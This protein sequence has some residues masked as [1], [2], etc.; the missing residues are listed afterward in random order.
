[1]STIQQ[2]RDDVLKEYCYA[3]E[4]KKEALRKIEESEQI[5]GNEQT[6]VANWVQ[7]VKA[8]DKMMEACDAKIA[9]IDSLNN[10]KVRFYFLDYT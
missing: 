10:P 7:E 2:S 5:I 8:H 6:K 1:M 9:A 4:K 3:K